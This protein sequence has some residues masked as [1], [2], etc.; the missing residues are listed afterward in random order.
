MNRQVT[1]EAAEELWPGL[2]S[3]VFQ[4]PHCSICPSNCHPKE[5][6]SLLFTTFQLRTR[7]INIVRA[8]V[9]H[10]KA[11]RAL[12][13]GRRLWKDNG[14]QWGWG[15][16]SWN[17]QGHKGIHPEQDNFSV[18]YQAHIGSNKSQSTT[19]GHCLPYRIVRQILQPIFPVSFT[20]FPFSLDWFTST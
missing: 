17:G 18:P 13:T 1:V 15:G 16:G 8:Q 14:L 19:P 3:D 9:R 6:G 10:L 12:V 20:S 4:R 5:W 11:T 7:P 2:P